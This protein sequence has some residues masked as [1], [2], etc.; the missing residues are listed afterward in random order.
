MK[1]VFFIKIDPSVKLYDSMKHEYDGCVIPVV[2]M[3]IAKN[4]QQQPNMQTLQGF[5]STVDFVVPVKAYR[6]MES[7]NS[8]ATEFFVPRL[9]KKGNLI[10]SIR[11]SGDNLKGFSD[12]D[13]EAVTLPAFEEVF[14]K[15]K[16]SFI[17]E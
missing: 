14:G 2:H 12:K 6:D 15:G 17:E 9:E 5:R 13:I 7:L 3:N 16:V 11:I 10:Q 4:Q 8:D 1:Q